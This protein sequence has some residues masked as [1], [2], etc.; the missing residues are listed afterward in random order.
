[1]VSGR[2]SEAVP[3]VSASGVAGGEASG[4]SGHPLV[5]SQKENE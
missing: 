1:M 4:Q 5:I 2:V 3:V